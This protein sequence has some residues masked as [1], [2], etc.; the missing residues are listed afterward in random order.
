M[1]NPTSAPN[2]NPLF[3]KWLN[4]GPLDSEGSKGP[5]VLRVQQLCF[6]HGVAEPGLECDGVYTPGGKTVDSVK[7]LQLEKLG[8]TGNAV[9]GNFGDATHK[10]VKAKL[11]VDLRA[12]PAVPGQPTTWYNDKNE[13]MGAWPKAA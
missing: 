7:R 8:F 11:G 3:P 13:Y 12:L 4:A 2:F 5:A 1:T 10:A 6:E 9:D